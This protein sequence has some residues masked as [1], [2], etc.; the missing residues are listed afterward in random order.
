MKTY[1]TLKEVFLTG[2][3]FAVRTADGWTAHHKYA[4]GRKKIYCQYPFSGGVAADQ[5]E[6]AFQVYDVDGLEPKH[7]GG[8]RNI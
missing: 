5:P 8:D 7:L 4:V 3:R 2:C 1:T 6:G